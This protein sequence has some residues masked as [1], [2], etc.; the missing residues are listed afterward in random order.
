MSPTRLPNWAR[1]GRASWKINGFSKSVQRR[2]HG[3]VDIAAGRSWYVVV[4][5]T[6]R[7]ARRC[8][9]T[10]VLLGPARGKRARSAAPVCGSRKVGRAEI[11]VVE[12]NNWLAS[13]RRRVEWPR[14]LA[15]VAAGRA[16]PSVTAAGSLAAGDLPTASGQMPSPMPEEDKQGGG[17]PVHNTN[18]RT[19]RLDADAKSRVRVD[20]GP[21]W[22]SSAGQRGYDRKTDTSIKI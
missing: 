17:R 12:G 20:S 6:T 13:C 7:S 5:I 19:I 9:T 2:R 11:P 10:S 18:A 21:A 22:C 3:T 4:A 16:H 15:Q 8:R 14:C 1:C